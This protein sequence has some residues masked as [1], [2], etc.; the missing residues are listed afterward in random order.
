MNGEHTYACYDLTSDDNLVDELA[1][2]VRDLYVDD[3]ALSSALVEAAKGLDSVCDE[4]AIAKVIDEVAIAVIPQVDP[5]SKVPKHLQV[6]RN[7]VAEVLALYVLEQI[8]N[9][10]VPSSRIR[11]KEV[12]GL[13]SRGLD[14]LGLTPNS[15]VVLT[16]VKASSSTSSP[17]AVVHTARDSMHAE[18]LRRLNNR[19]SV[20]GELHWALK[21]A[22]SEAR[23]A[24]ARALL[25]HGL[26]KAPTPTVAPVLVRAAG[27]YKPSDFGNFANPSKEFGQSPIRFAVIRLPGTLEDFAAVVYARAA[28][29]AA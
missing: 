22:K 3:L 21:H 6:P 17:P 15:A 12:S 23:E 4:S 14:V 27:T 11:N 20:L 26:S 2:I 29:Q 24:T 25:L 1:S 19:E 16:E 8:H 13:P 9:F 18:T 10:S 28:E 5:Q 7:E